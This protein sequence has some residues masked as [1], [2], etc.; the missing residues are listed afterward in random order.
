MTRQD[1]LEVL[2]RSL[3][4]TLQRA[5]ALIGPEVADY[6]PVL[7]KGLGLL[8]RMLRARGHKDTLAML[9][10]LAAHAPEKL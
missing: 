8:I 1:A 7:T 10:M 9:E 2:H 3:D 4:L 5:V 6:V